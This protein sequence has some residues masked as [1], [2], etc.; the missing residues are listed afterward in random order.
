[1]FPN[2]SQ[3]NY[4]MKNI[5]KIVSISIITVSSFFIG[6]KK[7]DENLEKPTI[8]TTS[9]VTQITTISAICAGNV[10]KDGGLLEFNRKSNN[11]KF[12]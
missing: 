6:C 9:L 12:N 1:M 7:D 5:F 8:T 11:I 4:K 2:F 10:S 3:N